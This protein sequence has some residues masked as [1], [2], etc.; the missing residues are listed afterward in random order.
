MPGLGREP[1]T[2]PGIYQIIS[3]AWV[4]ATKKLVRGSLDA[5]QRYTRVG[6]R[7]G[8]V[9][10]AL[11]GLIDQQFTGDINIFPGYGY[12]SLGKLLKVLTEEEMRELIKAGERGTWPKIPI[13][14]TTT[15]IGRTI[16]KILH[17]YELEQTHWLKSSPNTEEYRSAAS[18]PAKGRKRASSAAPSRSKKKPATRDRRDPGE[19][20]AAV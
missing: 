10:N 5:V 3:D 1:S 7:T 8:S 16:D 14:R 20:V 18:A 11:N 9:L 2:R 4:A 19:A 15:R 6:A 13:I 17:H 12:S